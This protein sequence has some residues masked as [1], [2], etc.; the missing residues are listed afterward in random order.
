MAGFFVDVTG[1]SIVRLAG[2]EGL[3][4]LQ[5]I[6]TNDILPLKSGEKLQTILTN[7]KGRIVDVVSVFPHGPDNLLLAGSNPAPAVLKGWIE[8]F[9]I[10]EDLSITDVTPDYYELVLFG[11]EQNSKEFQ[12]PPGADFVFEKWGSETLLRVI[13]DVGSFDAAVRKLNE[14]GIGKELPG[15]F[16]RYRIT[17]GIPVFPSE[18][19]TTYNPLEAGLDGM[20]SWTKGCYVGQEVIARLDTYKKVQRKLVKLRLD[21]QPEQLPAMIFVQSNEVGMLTSASSMFN[22]ESVGGLG[23]I[24][25]G[26]VG[27]NEELLIRSGSESIRA[28]L[29]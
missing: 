14:G 2:R 29:I 24:K 1:R 3:D 22:D 23:Y 25:I 17:K 16:E 27:L 11:L 12:A 15:L 18:L 7:D 26:F 20:V 6:S 5:R 10:M 8:K 13:G 21:K 9:I 28:R 4:L 19:S